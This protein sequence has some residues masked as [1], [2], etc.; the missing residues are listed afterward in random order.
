ME[1]VKGCLEKEPFESVTMMVKLESTCAVGVPEIVT[2]RPVLLPSESP[3]V[4]EPDAM[5]HMKGETPPVAF[6]VAVYALPTF[7]AGRLVDVTFSDPDELLHPPIAMHA[8]STAK[9][10]NRNPARFSMTHPLTSF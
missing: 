10:G 5:D 9:N 8:T 7:P 3:A 2:E 4:S 6:T 1:M